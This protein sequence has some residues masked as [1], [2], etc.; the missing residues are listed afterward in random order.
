MEREQILS[1]D[2][3]ILLSWTNMK[4]RDYFDSLE[5]LCEDYD[6]LEEEIEGKLNSIGYRYN[7]HNNR[8]IPV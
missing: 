1:M 6:V 7:H 8:F 5:E 2:S 3:F 4:L